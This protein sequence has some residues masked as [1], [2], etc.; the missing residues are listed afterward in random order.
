[1]LPKIP[2]YVPKWAEEAA[3]GIAVA[4]FAYA[5]SAI[6]ANGVPNDSQA[7]IAL[8]AGALPIAW[9]ALR[10]A[11]NST[12]ATPDAPPPIIGP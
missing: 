11:L 8:V 12:P 7:I 3:R 10:T 1:M 2:W 9:A 5:V 6:A 4:V